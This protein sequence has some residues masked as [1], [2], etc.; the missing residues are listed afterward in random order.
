V[1]D[2]TG[3]FRGRIGPVNERPSRRTHLRTML[4]RQLWWVAGLAFVLA[5]VLATLSGNPIIV[6][7]PTLVILLSWAAFALPLDTVT[8]AVVFVMVSLNAPSS[9]PGDKVF[10]F[11]LN[12]FGKLLYKNLPTKFAVAD[13]IVLLLAF[14]AV[15]VVLL[16]RAGQG[17]DRHP[18]KPFAQACL[19]A[20]MAIVG[21]E[22]WGV[23]LGG[24]DFKNSLW[25]LRVPLLVPCLALAVSVA[26][27]DTGIRRI[28]L[29]LL[30]AGV[31]KA[32]EAVYGYWIFGLRT[33]PDAIFV[34]QHADS[35]LWAVCVAILCSEWFEERRENDRRRLLVLMPLYMLAMVANNRRTVWVA[36]AGGLFFIVAT[37]H[38]PVKRQLVKLFALTWPLLVM[39]VVVGLSSSSAVFKPVQMV[40]SVLFQEDTSSSTRDVENFNLLVTLRARPLV[41]WGFG[42]KYIEVVQAYDISKDFAQY[43]F[44]PHN[45]FLGFW[46]FNGLIGAGAYFLLFVVGVFYLVS[47]RRTSRV[48]SRR[49]AATW[50]VC[51]VIA[52]L[53]QSWSD[54]ALQDWTPMVCLGVALGIGGALGRSVVAEGEVK[55]VRPA[56]DYVDLDDAEASPVARPLTG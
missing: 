50:S 35:V 32:F 47:A 29:A 26:A 37:A 46:A 23:F 4:R 6:I 10:N 36:I 51:A 34:T 33:N 19:I 39:Y 31:L 41:G 17:V 14:R 15:T 27:T 52:Y 9:N 28:R 42:H 54:L 21:C 16:G 30:G 20:V 24:G 5:S 56:L 12:P 2:L 3:P 55:S 13:V 18:P 22:V 45:S 53:V 49:A 48:P 8:P 25:Q 44:L 1:T 7:A 38:R 40:Q 43:R 11:F